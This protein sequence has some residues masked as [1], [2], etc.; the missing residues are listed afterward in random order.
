MRPRID[1]TGFGFIVIDGE[2]F[3]KD[4]VIEGSGAIRKRKKKLSKER[5]GTSHVLS[6]EEAEDVYGAGA[7]WLIIGTGHEDMVRL[8]PEAAEYFEANKCR[9]ELLATPLAAESW[10][11]AEGPGVG[12]FHI[13][14]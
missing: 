11:A 2:R 9:V 10:N 13:T 3:E 5:F 12:L 7:E 4:V 6:L 1:K 14:C 8:S